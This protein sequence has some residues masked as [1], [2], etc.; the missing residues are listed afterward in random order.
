MSRKDYEI[1]IDGKCH[2]VFFSSGMLACKAQG[3]TRAEM[4]LDR[5]KCISVRFDGLSRSILSRFSFSL[6]SATDTYR[7]GGCIIIGR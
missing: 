7:S 3:L 1:N 5:N 4:A 6:T 2:D